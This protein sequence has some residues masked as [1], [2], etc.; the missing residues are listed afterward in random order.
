MKI[1]EPNFERKNLVFKAYMDDFNDIN[2]F[3]NIHS[4]QGD[5]II[6]LTGDPD[7]VFGNTY[8]KIPEDENYQNIGDPRLLRVYRY[9]DPSHKP[10]KNIKKFDRAK[11]SKGIMLKIQ[12][13]IDFLDSIISKI[14]KRI[15]NSKIAILE[16]KYDQTFQDDT[17]KR[18]VA[19]YIW[20]PIWNINSEKALI[21]NIRN[22]IFLIFS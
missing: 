16:S 1:L 21:V 20:I 14:P 5:Y 22:R 6:P 18:I 15:L 12:S 4:H 11:G 13:L 2:Q 7:E 3:I 17:T 10:L 8:T 19:N 9:Y